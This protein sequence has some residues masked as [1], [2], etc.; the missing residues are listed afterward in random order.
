M[1]VILQKLPSGALAPTGEEEAE[2][3]KRLKIGAGVRCEVVQIR[4]YRFFKKYWAL[5]KY[6]FGLW[7]EWLPRERYRG[8][9]VRA[10]LKK[11]QEGLT[12]LTGRYTPVSD[13]LGRTTLQAHSISFA[14]M[15]E[16]EF[17]QLYS[18]TIQVALGRVLSGLNLNEAAVRAHVDE[19]LRYDS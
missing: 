2:K 4:N 9:E 18:D 5:V 16:D 6:L 19:I 8:Q 17:Q 11:F 14:K 3:L 13:V 12:I 15:E 10:N 1:E 7:E